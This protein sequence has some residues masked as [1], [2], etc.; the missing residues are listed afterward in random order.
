MSAWKGYMQ[1]TVYFPH[2]YLER[3]YELDISIGSKEKIRSTKDVGKSKP[4]IFEI[5]NEK[6]LADFEMV[7]KLKIACR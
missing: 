1:A 5:R 7:M 2:K 6:V 4:C 3:V